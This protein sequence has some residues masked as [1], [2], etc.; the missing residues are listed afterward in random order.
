MSKSSSLCATKTFIFIFILF[1]EMESCSV[2]RLESSGTLSAHCNLHLLG[3]SDFPASA[4][5]VTGTT[6]LCHYARLI[7]FILVEMRFHH[8]G[9]G[10]RW[11]R[12]PDFMIR[13]PRPS[14]VLGLQC[15]DL[16]FH[17]F[18]RNVLC[19]HD[20]HTHVFFITIFITIVIFIIIIITITII[21]IVIAVIIVTSIPMI[22]T[23]IIITTIIFKGVLLHCP[24]WSEMAQSWLTATSTSQVQA[25]LLPQPPEATEGPW[26]WNQLDQCL[27]FLCIL[28]ECPLSTLS[29]KC[30]RLA[31]AVSET[32]PDRTRSMSFASIRRHVGQASVPDYETVFTKTCI[33]RSRRRDN[34]HYLNI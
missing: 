29:I 3:S 30:V 28:F 14:K 1:F 26:K 8:V 19:L 32:G 17:I 12:S 20:Y 13:L 10:G 15:K 23:T 2:T 7:F 24:G 4:S 27:T 33:H 9:Q 34:L 6:G 22:I 16:L 31:E 18:D 25:I 21:T 5:Q 11:S